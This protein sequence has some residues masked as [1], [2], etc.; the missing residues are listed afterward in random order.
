MNQVTLDGVYLPS[1]DIVAREIEGELII[2]PLTSAVGDGEDE[3]YTLNETARE[4]WALLDGRRTLRQVAAAL[5]ES[6]DAPAVEIE[7]DV[8]GLAD[9][10]LQRKILAAA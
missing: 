10:L 5:S 2:V 3:L 4:V 6:F 1:D 8:L 7:Q 9:E